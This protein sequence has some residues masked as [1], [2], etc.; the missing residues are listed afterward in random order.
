MIAFFTHTGNRTDRTVL[1]TLTAALTELRIDDEATQCLTYLRTAPL[2]ADML[3]VF[4]AELT[5]RREHRKRCTLAKSAQRH[6]LD[7]IA[8]LLQL[9]NITHLTLA[10]DDSLQNLQHTLRPLAARYAF[11]TRLTLCKAHEEAGYLYHAGMLIH[12]NKSAGADN[13]AIL[14]YRIEIQWHIQ[15]LF[16]QTSA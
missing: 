11:A 4:I 14:L 15:M 10:G 2:I 1:R 7:H 16:R 8:E 6:T 5:D 13:R 3:L 9:I 12:D